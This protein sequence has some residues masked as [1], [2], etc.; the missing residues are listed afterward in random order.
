MDFPDIEKRFRE[1]ELRRREGKVQE[2]I[3]H[4]DSL[5][6]Y[7]GSRINIS[8]AV[9]TAVIGMAAATATSMAYYFRR[10]NK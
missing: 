5:E 3:Q 6:S 2:V 7:S 8:A 9:I 1:N 4:K 10:I